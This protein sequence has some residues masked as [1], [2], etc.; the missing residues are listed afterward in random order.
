[1][2]NNNIIVDS[3]IVR[4]VYGLKLNVTFKIV[5]S[6]KRSERLFTN[7][8]VFVLYGGVVKSPF[9]IKEKKLNN[10]K[11]HCID[12]EAFLLINFSF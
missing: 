11:A 12:K 10:K 4:F 5:H 7:L 2:Y 3:K 8:K 1:M 9:Y 6:R